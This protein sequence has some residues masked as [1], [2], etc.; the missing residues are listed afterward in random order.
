[1][2]VNPDL[3]EYPSVRGC[4][5][6]IKSSIG[7]RTVISSYFFQS[8]PSFAMIFE[9][10]QY[11]LLLAF[12]GIPKIHTDTACERDVHESEESVPI[13]EYCFIFLIF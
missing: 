3:K 7:H 1:M 11:S 13:I 8:T 12:Q 2:H 5:M 4:K 9:S 6:I 10:N